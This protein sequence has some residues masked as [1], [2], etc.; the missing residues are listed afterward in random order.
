MSNDR[1]LERIR[2][3]LAMA[4]DERGNDHERE[5]ALRQAHAMLTKHGLDMMDVA[6]HERE[7][8]DPRGKHTVEGWSMVWSRHIHNAI[9][10]LFMCKYFYGKKINGTK[11]E[12]H[13]VGR[14]S[15]AL[16][17][18]YMSTYVVDNIL[19]EGRRQFGHNLAPGT[20][21]F[22]LGCAQRLSQR[23]SEMLAAKVEQTASDG[24]SLTLLDMVADEER[25]NAE[26]VAGWRFKRG[27]RGRAVA[28]TDAYAA[29]YEHGGKIN[30]NVQVARPDTLRLN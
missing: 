11:Q 10:R 29:G 15:N 26:F 30:L 21:E 16:T 3:L 17:A 22:A 25:A 20:R 6:E 18:M 13:F 23:V 7:K 5:T 1:I 12:H 8:V 4:N 14:E 28:K 27:S 9:G 24:R 2:K 19:K